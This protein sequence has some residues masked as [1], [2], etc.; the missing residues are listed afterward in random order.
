MESERSVQLMTPL[1]ARTYLGAY[2]DLNDPETVKDL[3]PLLDKFNGWQTIPVA[4]LQDRW[5]E[6]E[7]EEAESSQESKDDV[8]IPEL[9]N[10][11]ISTPDTSK[12]LRDGAM[13]TLLQAL[14]DGSDDNTGLLSE[15]EILTDFVPKLKS[16]LYE[17]ANFLKPSPHVLDLL[18][19]ALED[20]TEV[21][22]SPFKSL[23]AEDLS[24]VVSRL[25]KHGKMN[26]L[27]ISNMPDLT[28]EDLQLVLRGAADLKALYVLEDPQITLQAT[29]MLL[30]DCDLYHSDLLRR[31]IKDQPEAYVGIESRSPDDDIA[32]GQVW[33][34]SNVSQ[35][36][37]IGITDGQALDRSHRLESGLIDWKTL[38]QEKRRSH[39]GWSG[40]DLRYKRYPLDMPL[41]TFKTVTGLLR[42]LKW[43]SLS[44][45]YNTEDF[46]KGAACSF[47]L[48]SSIPGSKELGIGQGAGGNGFGIGALWASLY[49]DG[50]DGCIPPSDAHEHLE[51]SQW[52]IVLIHEAFDAISQKYLDERQG[53]K[54]VGADSDSEDDNSLKQPKGE[55]STLDAM[56]ALILAPEDPFKNKAKNQNLPFRAIK[57]LRYALVTPSTKSNPSDHDFIVADI[58]TYLEHIKGKFQDK[59]NGGDIQKLIEVWNSQIAAMDTVDFYGEEDIHDILPKVFRSSQK[60]SSSGSKPE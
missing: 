22:L 27:C 20:D 16:M 21:D 6:G 4:T 14:L 9:E 45:L 56:M 15:A 54:S 41:P 25:R 53:G 51:P 8:V 44:Q 5:P 55:E 2:Y 42:L 19:R 43:G 18:C 52:A 24:L 36:V 39:F 12:S 13:A 50:T 60:T 40:S 32:A 1:T 17:Q 28:D 7:W 29:S 58:P 37:W 57:R 34:G 33:R 23:S 59:G 31:P 47:A 26:V 48:A 49:L 10:S 30:S 35:L 11:E 38:R 46:S 3:N